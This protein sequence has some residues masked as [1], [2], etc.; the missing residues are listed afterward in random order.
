MEEDKVRHLVKSFSSLIF[1]W[2]GSSFIGLSSHL[3]NHSAVLIGPPACKRDQKSIWAQDLH[4][5]LIECLPRL[6]RGKKIMMQAQTSL[7]FTQHT[8]LASIPSR[9][10]CPLS[11]SSLSSIQPFLSCSF[12]VHLSPS[13]DIDLVKLIW[14]EWRV[15]NWRRINTVFFMCRLCPDSHESPCWQREAS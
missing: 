12:S 3:S 7:I 13:C 10:L 4:F 14:F 11:P 6:E 8:P 1:L 2:L 15:S 5:Y 9:S